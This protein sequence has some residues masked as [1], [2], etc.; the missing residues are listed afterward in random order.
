VRAQTRRE[1]GLWAELRALDGMTTRELAAKH[2]AVV[3]EPTRSNNRAYLIKRI[4]W[5][6]QEVAERGLSERA[7]ARIADLGD[8][9]PVRW[10]MRRDEGIGGEAPAAVAA[11]ATAARDPR[12]PPPGSVLVRLHRGREHRVTV[13]DRGFEH[14]GVVY[15]TLSQ[16]ARAISGQHTSGFAFFARALTRRD[17]A[18]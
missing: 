10:R 6:L 7:W 1:R 13:H 18:A 8:E 9:L 14:E 4:A 16:V 11:A 12:L 5:R 2:E 17:G 3:G 15:A